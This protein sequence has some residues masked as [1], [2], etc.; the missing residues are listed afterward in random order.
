M[1]VHNQGTPE[2]QY[3]SPHVALRLFILHLRSAL[4]QFN[5]NSVFTSSKNHTALM[6]EQK[7]VKPLAVF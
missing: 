5:F 4:M 7:I 3:A 2:A 1:E 6:E